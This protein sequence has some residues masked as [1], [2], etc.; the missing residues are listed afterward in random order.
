M[1]HTVPLFPFINVF[2]AEIRRK[3]N[4][5]HIGIHQFPCVGHRDSI[6]CRAEYQIT[7]FEIA[8]VRV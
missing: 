5:P 3:V 1:F 6:G 7:S 4:Q 2:Q 8:L